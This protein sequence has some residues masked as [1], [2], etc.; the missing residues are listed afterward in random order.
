V[1]HIR[2]GFF[3]QKLSSPASIGAKAAM[4]GQGDPGRSNG[5][6]TSQALQIII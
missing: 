1:K 6:N 5:R 2:N 4:R 3:N